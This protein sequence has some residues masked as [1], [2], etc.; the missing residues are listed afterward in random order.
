MAF[1][2]LLAG[3][4]SGA[5]ALGKN[6][7]ETQKFSDEQSL[8]QQRADLE[9][10]KAKVIAQ[11]NNENAKSL[12]QYSHNL[13]TAPL[14]RAAGYLSEATNETPAIAPTVQAA[15]PAARLRPMGDDDVRN[16][17]AAITVGT[18]SAGNP[19]AVG[20]NI[21]GQGTAK[22]LYQVMDATNA[23]PGYGVAPAQDASAQER[24]RV[25]RDYLNA[26]LD[27]YNGDPSKAWAAYN[28]GPGRLD[29]AIKEGGEDW[30]SKLPAETQNY[31]AKNLAQL[32][33]SFSKEQETPID[34]GAAAAITAA[35]DQLTSVRGKTAPSDSEILKVAM[36]KALA[37][38]DGEGYAALQKLA[39]ENQQISRGNFIPA[40]YGG[41]VN[42]DT[43]E[44]V[45]ATREDIVNKLEQGRNERNA[46]NI[47][48]KSQLQQNKFTYD[49]T[50]TPEDKANALAIAN[51][52]LPAPTGIA[53]KNPKNR[54]IMAEVL[55]IKPD[56]SAR[57]YGNV[58]AAEKKFLS[59]KA[60]DSIK[61]FNVSISHLDTLQGLADALQN[62]NLPLVNK[63]GNLYAQ[64]TGK[65]APVEFDAAKKIVGDELVKA[66]VGSGGA[67]GDRESMEKTLSNASSPAQLKGVIN[68]YQEL[69]AGQLAGLS[70][71]YRVSTGRSDFTKFLSDEAKDLFIHT[72]VGK[73]ATAGGGATAPNPFAPNTAI[74]TDVADLLNKYR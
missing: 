9:T 52:Q 56:Y 23:S 58:S 48:A 47:A 25:G 34:S 72:D 17:I 39:D 1:G 28:A 20:P 46:A 62:N 2:I 68:T 13:Q 19:N 54:L 41:V 45:G 18:E 35:R 49:N 29:A 21:P 38:N 63:L 30:L 6:L 53:S 24:E 10:E 44:V 74:P 66:I 65:P 26:M 7:A 69:M 3:L 16:K 37:A 31:V 71:Q 40:G 32:Q 36:R 4:S 64:Q 8:M 14:S 22:G 50:L 57:D 60:S 51:G 61:S 43:G 59:G 15:E 12:A 33:G 11:Y 27:K 55:N 70:Q 73:K 42:L 5:E 67:L